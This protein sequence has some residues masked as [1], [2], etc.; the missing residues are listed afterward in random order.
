MRA[1]V[2]AGILVATVGVLVSSG[3]FVP[4]AGVDAVGEDLTMQPVEPYAYTDDANETVIDVGPTNPN[5]D[6]GVNPAAVTTVG[7]VVEITN[8]GDSPAAVWIDADLQTATFTQ[9]GVPINETTP[10]ELAP[11]ETVTVGLTLNST[12]AP[13]IEEPDWTIVGDEL[14]DSASSTRFRRPVTVSVEQTAPTRRQISVDGR[15][16]GPVD[17]E[18]T[19]PVLEDQLRLTQVELTLSSATTVT[20]EGQPYFDAQNASDQHPPAGLAGTVTL[21]Q[22]DDRVEAATFTFQVNRSLTSNGTVEVFHRGPEGWEPIETTTVEANDDELRVRARATTFSTFGV[23][24]DPPPVEATV[25]A[26]D[27][28]PAGDPVTVPVTVHN[29]GAVPTTATVSFNETTVQNVTLSGEETQTIE[30]TD[31]VTTPGQYPV[32]VD[33][34]QI[35]TVEVVPAPDPADQ[36]TAQGP[37]ASPSPPPIEP[38]FIDP[39][40]I[41]VVLFAAVVALVGGRHLRQHD[42]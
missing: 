1:L 18:M 13:V 19:V 2:V 39:Y 15:P 4:D 17:A 35:S 22:A 30:L 8:D 28:V 42:V 3:A 32:V 10:R 14:D 6:A 27:P 36:L 31:T 37:P 9:D 20:V 25:G 5:L 34:E 38:A 21:T 11:A 7:P 24:V 40:R 12:D 29:R 41:L 16:R 33:G 26:L 23:F